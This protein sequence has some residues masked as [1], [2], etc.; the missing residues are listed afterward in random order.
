VRDKSRQSVQIGSS[1]QVPVTAIFPAIRCFLWQAALAPIHCAVCIVSITR[2]MPGVHQPDPPGLIHDD[3][4]LLPPWRG[5]SLFWGFLSHYGYFR[6]CP[7][8][9]ERD[10]HSAHTLRFGTFALQ[11]GFP[12]QTPWRRSRWVGVWPTRCGRP[13]W[14]SCSTWP[15]P[16]AART[17]LAQAMRTAVTRCLVEHLDVVVTAEASVPVGKDC[18]APGRHCPCWTG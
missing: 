7:V 2:L 11:I 17:A 4:R 6:H 1:R 15:P 8:V 18:V 10:F 5:S 16:D 9:A 13:Q 3:L 12:P 14:P